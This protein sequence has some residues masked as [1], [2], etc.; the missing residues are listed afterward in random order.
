MLPSFVELLNY[1]A[2]ILKDLQ[3][4]VIGLSVFSLELSFYYTSLNRGICISNEI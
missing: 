4:Y 1:K 3:N 2:Y